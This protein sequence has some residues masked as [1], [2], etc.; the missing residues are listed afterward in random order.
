MS[1]EGIDW[2]SD[3]SLFL[4]NPRLPDA[5][6]TLLAQLQCE[7]P[8]IPSCIWI[9]TSGSTS[10][11]Q[12]K[13]VAL[14]KAAFLASAKAVNEHIES[15]SSDIW[16]NALPNFHVGGLAVWARAFLSHAKVVE[17]VQAWDPHKFHFALEKNKVTLSSL[18]PTQ[19]YDL[20]HI[21]LK[22]PNSVRVIFVGGGAMSD[23]L[24]TKARQLGYPVL[25]TYGMTET[26]SQI[27]TAGLES[28]SESAFPQARVLSHLELKSTTEGVLE[29]KGDSLLQGVAY[30]ENNKLRYQEHLN[31][32]W[33]STGDLGSVSSGFVKIRGRKTEMLKV[34][35]ELVSFPRLR[36]VLDLLC[37][38]LEAT[39][40]ALPDERA[41]HAVAIVFEMTALQNAYIEIINEFNDRVAAF[42]KITQVYFVNKIPKSPLGKIKTAELKEQLGA[43]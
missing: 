32:E 3:E 19:L 2:H 41:G 34:L 7:L 33:F 16:L 21:G 35:G 27:A 14:K 5:E 40:L 9:L 18:V 12:Y 11:N 37:H 30:I 22:C 20:V 42:E 8:D 43:L 10:I 36:T 13:W 24:Y 6:K 39:I 17:Y 15:S 31:T 23:E 28:L 29:V 25:P 26:C 38:E 4:H 1:P